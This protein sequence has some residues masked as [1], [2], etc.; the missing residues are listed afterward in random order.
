ML[1]F[2]GSAESS[3]GGWRWGKGYSILVRLLGSVV[4]LCDSDM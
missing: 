3:V 2:L 1:L 4:V